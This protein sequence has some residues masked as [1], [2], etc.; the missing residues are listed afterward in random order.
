MRVLVIGSGAREHAVAQKFSKSK[1]IAG[2]FVLPGNAGTSE[3]AVNIDGDYGDPD[4]VLQVCRKNNINFVFIGPEAPLAAGLADRIKDEGIPV[5]GP[6]A[7]AAQLESSKVFSKEFMNR[8][9]IPTAEARTFSESGPFHE[10][11]QSAAGKQV[12]KKNGLAAGKGVFESESKDELIDFG[13]KIISGGD[14]L[15]A[16]EFLEGFE[17]SIIT[18]YDGST[19]EILP[20]AADYKKAGDG[21]TGPNTGGM[22]A[23]CPVPWLSGSELS[24]VKDLIIAPTFQGLREDGLA[25]TGFLYF[26]LMITPAGPKI[27]EYNVRLGDPETQ[28]LLPLIKSDFGNLCEAMTSKKLDTFPLRV[29]EKS[30]LGVV[31]A[32]PGYP[33]SY[34][35]SIPVTRLPIVHESEAAV[36]H[37]STYKDSTG[38]LKTGGG[39]CFTV[40]GLGKD[41][42]AARITAYNAV[43]GVQFSGSWYRGDIGADVYDEAD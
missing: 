36:Y 9:Q 4:Y 2:L 19:Y 31:V 26:G 14:S 16:E 43:K 37:A 42:L 20:P 24:R 10:Y 17:V 12:I 39:R 18:I 30:A 23:I 28:V 5:I 38:V 35:K 21:N 3:I 41:L 11:I 27:L 15:L 29:A 6:G 33:G 13:D 32:A 22:G 25:F 34:E 1:R 40:V 7:K 8:H